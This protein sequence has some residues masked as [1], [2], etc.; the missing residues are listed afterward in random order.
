MITRRVEIKKYGWALHVYCAVR[1]YFVEDILMHLADI[2]CSG[3]F[4][5]EAE[6]NMRGGTLN[7]GLT[8]SNWGSRE[9]VLVVGLAS[10]PEEYA[11][12]IVHEL[13]HF[14]VHVSRALGLDMEGE[15]PAYL[16]GET[17]RELMGYVSPLVCCHC[18]AR[19]R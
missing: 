8:Y 16:I 19:V 5:E 11:N 3:E 1:S 12:S 4:L 15:E 9:T 18:R 13:W 14:A 6:R 10:S 2:G 7:R 17:M